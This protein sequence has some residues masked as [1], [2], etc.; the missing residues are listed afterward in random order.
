MLQV[1]SIRSADTAAVVILQRLRD[2]YLARTNHANCE[3]AHCVPPHWNEN[4]AEDGAS[5]VNAVSRAWY[6]LLLLPFVAMLWV[7][8]YNSIEPTSWG[9]PFFY[10][11]PLLWV[12]VCAVV[13]S[14]TIPGYAAVYALVLNIAVAA[15][16]SV[17]CRMST[18]ARPADETIAS[19]YA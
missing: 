5:A 8:S 18:L 3:R 12:T 1:A 15:I 7:G 4:A 2:K 17:L 6:L 13:G 16:V 11:Y 19:D 9:F 10:W 14:L